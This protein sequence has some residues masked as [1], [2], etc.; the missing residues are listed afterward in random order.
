MLLSTGHQA[1]L[2]V[3]S[4]LGEVHV[5]LDCKLGR[6]ISSPLNRNGFDQYKKASPSRKQRNARR[7]ADREERQKVVADGFVN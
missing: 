4:H 5:S 3:N 7:V 2:N 1:S 6:I